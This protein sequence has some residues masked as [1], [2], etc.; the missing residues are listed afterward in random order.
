MHTLRRRLSSF[1]RT[2]RASRLYARFHLLLNGCASRFE[3]RPSMFET[4]KLPFFQPVSIFNAIL[5]M[6]FRPL[7]SVAHSRMVDTIKYLPVVIFIIVLHKFSEMN[8]GLNFYSRHVCLF[9]LRRALTP[10]FA[11]KRMPHLLRGTLHVA[12]RQRPYDN[13]L[14]RMRL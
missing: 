13:K 4:P 7:D 12:C 9:C 2:S 6:P 10:R 11:L 5:L 14:N 1:S 8:Y 3:N